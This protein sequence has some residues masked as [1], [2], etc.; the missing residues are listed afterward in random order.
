[1]I[2]KLR[3]VVFLLL[4]I[5]V[6]FFYGIIHRQKMIPYMYLISEGNILNGLT[7]FMLMSKGFNS[8]QSWSNKTEVSSNKASSVQENMLLETINTHSTTVNTLFRSPSEV[9][10]EGDGIIFLET[11]DRLQLPSLILC[12]IES[13]ARVYKNRPVAFFLKGLNNSNIEEMVKTHFPMLS[14]LKNINFF[15]LRLEEFFTDTPLL[16]WYKKVNPQ[17]EMHW[18]HVSADGC[19]LALIWKHG[20]IYMDTDII[21][22]RAIPN[23][24]FLAAQ[25]SQYSS[26]GIFGFSSHHNFTQTCMEDFVQNY[27]SRR[28]GHQGPNLFTRVLKKFCDIPKFNGT[29]DIM[30]GNITFFNPQRFYPISYPMWK[31]Y[32][33]VWDKLPTFNDSYALHLWNFMNHVNVTMVPGSNMLAEHLYKEYCPSTY[34]A[35]L[36]NVTTY[37]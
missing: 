14:S 13:A 29:E 5:T 7:S 25:S 20:G 9:L 10:K 11:S 33:K 12:A 26:N 23:Q 2:K 15:P 19:R 35:I 34:D 4:L 3:I 1:M 28:W 24:D 6:G 22:I 18:I 31:S 27:N 30:C 32:Y 36:R 16:S 37:H 17:K 8:I 21:S